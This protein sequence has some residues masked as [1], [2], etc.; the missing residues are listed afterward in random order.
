MVKAMNEIAHALGKK[1][2]AEFVE[3]EESLTLLA[4]FGVDYAQGY[5]LGRPEIVWPSPT[6]TDRADMA[7]P[8]PR[9]GVSG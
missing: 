3:D 8:I 9:S 1:T 2:V 7:S 5:H 4:G 6:A